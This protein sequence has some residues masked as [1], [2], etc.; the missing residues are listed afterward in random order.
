MKLGRS[1]MTLLSFVS[2]HGSCVTLKCRHPNQGILHG[3]GGRTDVRD[4]ICCVNHAPHFN[5]T[6]PF[7]REIVGRG[8]AITASFLPSLPH[9]HA[10]PS[11]LPQ[12]LSLILDC[13]GR[14]L[15][16]QRIMRLLVYF[17]RTNPFLSLSIP[18]PCFKVSLASSAHRRESG[19]SGLI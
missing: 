3:R 7:Y 5:V 9:R 1:A 4:P 13:E 17:P 14:T 19:I 2:R 11:P 15:N 16:A 6:Q 8:R 10:L 18:G 12:Y